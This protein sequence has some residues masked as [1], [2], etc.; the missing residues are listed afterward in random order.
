MKMLIQNNAGLKKEIMKK[1]LMLKQAK[2]E[3]FEK[4][5]NDTQNGSCNVVT[6][7]LDEIMEMMFNKEFKIWDLLFDP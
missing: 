5:M 1:P 7:Q 2:D 3:R 4:N 6:I